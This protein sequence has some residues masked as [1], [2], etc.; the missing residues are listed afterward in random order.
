MLALLVLAFFTP[1][2]AV[3]EHT[4]QDAQPKLTAFFD[5]G[6]GGQFSGQ[7]A[8][9]IAYRY[10]LNPQGTAAIVVATGYSENMQKYSEIAYD[11]YQKGFSV[12]LFD[13]RGQGFSE[14]LLP[15]AR[16]A[17]VDDFSAFT[18]DLKTYFDTVVKVQ[19]PGLKHFLV[20]HSMG[21]AISAR[22]SEE[23]PDDFDKVVLSAPMLQIN[24]HHIPDLVARGILRVMF[25]FGLED[26]YV[27]GPADP[28]DEKFSSNQV[29]HS[30]DRFNVL[31]LAINRA[32]PEAQVWGLTASWLYHNLQG[33]DAISG[34]PQHVHVPMLLFQ[35]EQDAFVSNATEEDFCGRVANCRIQKFPG[36]RHEILMETDSIRDLA[37]EAIDK[38]VRPDRVSDGR[39]SSSSF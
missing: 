23:Y 35:A 29:T 28:L 6:Q 13:H 30:E 16:R 24:L 25:W 34:E 10:F 8:K 4:L 3:P 22:Y 18:R 2:W 37:L 27:N 21:G 32:H 5:G 12:F 39:S 17:D 36:A 19:T 33:L 14:H 7:R 20:G 31:N 15:D 11:L 9:K 26:A 1:A 38:F